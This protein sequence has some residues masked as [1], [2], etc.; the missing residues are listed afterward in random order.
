MERY[1]DGSLD[2]K[3]RINDLLGRLTLRVKLSL[4]I[5]TSPPNERLGIPKYDHGN[6]A[7]HGVVRPGR[8][9][10]FPQAIALGATFDEDLVFEIA[11]AISDEARAR[12]HAGRGDIPAEEYDARYSG[13]LTF[14]SPDMNLARD[15]RWGRTGET[16]GEDPYLAGRLGVAFVQGM[17]GDDPQ[18]LKTVST[19][20]HYTA[21]NEEHN[22]FSCNAAISDKSLREYYLAP[23]RDT[24]VAGGCAAVMAAYNAINGTPC[25]A[26]YQLLTAILR[27]E[28]GFNGY[29]VSDCSAIAR[30]W[31]AHKIYERPEAAAAAAMNAGVDLEC[32]GYSPYEHFYTTFLEEQVAAGAVAP[33]RIDE[34]CRRVLAARFRLGQFDPPEAVP[35]S[36]IPATVIGCDKHRALAYQ[37]ACA[38]IVLLKNNGILPLRQDRTVAVFGN[39]AA[40]CQFGDYSGKPVH[41]PVSPLDGIRAVVGK[42]CVH[43]AWNSPVR[44]NGFTVVASDFIDTLTGEYHANPFFHGSC[45]AR[46]DTVLDFTWK[47]AM[48]DPI[49]T[50]QQFSVRWNGKLKPPES[51]EYALRLVWSGSRPCEQPRLIIDD[52]EYGTTA[53]LSLTAGQ[54]VPFTV[55]YCRSGDDPSIRLEWQVPWPVA[56][57]A[58]ARE[59]EAADAADAVI[60]VIG[61]GTDYERE[62]KDKD[63]LDLPAEQLELLKQVFTVNKNLVVILING[64]PLTIPWV[65]A[66]A[67]AVVEAWYPGEQG[68]R[69]LADILYGA[70]NPS[71][72]LCVTFPNSTDD[73]P[74]FDRY[75]IEEGRTYLYSQAIPLYPFGFGLSYTSFAYADLTCDPQYRVSVELHNTGNRRGRE[76]VQLYLDSA[77]QPGQPTWRLVG[78]RCVELAAGE[79]RSVSF[80]LT[81]CH[82]SLFDRQGRRL[83]YPGIYRLAAGGSQ[84][85]AR[86]QALEAPQPVLCSIVL[87]GNIREITH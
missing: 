85:D 67:A 3:E 42:G 55:F 17:Q 77:G 69:A 48:P 5:E 49:I 64:S 60:A 50:T 45:T 61:L 34:A 16:Y 41:P 13:L 63:T 84:P 36:K 46:A 1:Q 10:V 8:F 73:L 58:F 15:P 14:W 79:Y 38:S 56:A 80:E 31:D 52:Q 44:E 72:R 57:D 81:E 2:F 65:H 86:S 59:C 75:D 82:F 11:S 71:G 12:Y 47:D 23:F 32:G 39:N 87:D 24:V 76:V 6:E 68:G 35:W 43:V 78:I 19:P 22:R 4:L 20:K 33:E 30:M 37:A 66:H 54:L 28:W 40:V 18:Y 74:A 51:G 9:T 27:D 26:S 83:V 21:N 62:G 53:Q 70:V 29:V 7:L 25:H